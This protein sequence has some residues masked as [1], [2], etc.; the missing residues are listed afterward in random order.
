M[1]QLNVVHCFPNA[2]RIF[3]III[4]IFPCFQTIAFLCEKL[5]WPTCHYTSNKS[6]KVF[7][8][9]CHYNQQIQ[10]FFLPKDIYL[11]TKEH[12]LQ[13]IFPLVIVCFMD[14]DQY[15]ITYIPF[16]SIGWVRALKFCHTIPAPST[17]TWK[18]ID[19]PPP[20]FIVS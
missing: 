12:S 14:F 10:H 11:L 16:T 8:I 3:F 6:H 13:Y 1:G 5:S 17:H 4:F 20:W 2:N 18:T 9:N 19:L 7:Y 15:E